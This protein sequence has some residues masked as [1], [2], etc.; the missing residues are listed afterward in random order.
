MLSRC[1]TDPACHGVPA[2]E[3]GCDYLV[4]ADNWHDHANVLYCIDG[5]SDEKS[6]YVCGYCRIVCEGCVPSLPL[7]SLL[8]FVRPRHG[9]LQPRSLETLYHT[10]TL[11]Q[12][13]ISIVYLIESSAFE[14]LNND[15]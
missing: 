9:R 1:A 13:D 4:L 8:S 15:R 6:T 5:D 3:D 14:G 10:Y 11:I 2:N 12:R 7:R